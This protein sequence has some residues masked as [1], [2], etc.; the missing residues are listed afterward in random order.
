MKL[1]WQISIIAILSLS[2]PW[3]VW[4]AFKSL[5]Q[6]FQDNMLAAAGK[7]A[8]VIVNSVQQYHQDRPGDLQGFVPMALG[9]EVAIDG[10]D[11][12]WNQIP[13]Y[14]VNHQLRFKLGRHQGL[15]HLFIE[16]MD[17][18]RYTSLTLPADRLVLATGEDRGIKKHTLKRQAVGQVF[19]ALGETDFSA[20]WHEMATGYQVEIKLLNPDLKRLGLAAINHATADSFISFGHLAGDQIQLTPIFLTSDN[21]QNFLQQITPEDGQITLKDPQGRVYQQT[22]NLSS[23]PESVGWL[24]EMIYE[25]AFDQNQADGSHFFGQRVQQNFAGGQI[26]LTIRHNQAQMALIRTFIRSVMWIFAIALALLLGYFLFAIVLAWRIRRLNKNLQNVLDER[27]HIHTALPSASAKDEIGDLSRGMS[28][29]LS[30]IDEYTEYLK[31]L[32]SRLSHEMKTPI[33]IVSTSLE[34][35]QMEQ[36]NNAFVSRALSANHRLKFI[37]NQLSALSKLKQVISETDKEPFELGSF[38]EELVN[39]Y[40]LNAEHIRCVVSNSPTTIAG[41]K[42]LMA[43]MLDKLIQNALDFTTSED[44]ITVELEHSNNGQNFELKVIN[45]GSQIPVEKVHQLFD[46]LTSFRHNKNSDEPH[47]GLGLYIARLICDYHQ[48]SIS[49]HNLNEA[50]VFVITGPL[51]NR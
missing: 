9:N 20:Y 51:S 32:G 24:T 19:Q 22:S 42:E 23:E 6:T 10:I 45:T 35:L 3:V 4:Q 25:L 1:K 11:T 27:G 30:Q 34:N 5:N 48:A 18:S 7:Q 8:Q 43:Q 40:R 2:F 33:S 26:E 41:S 49:A 14:H 47:L 44:R 12:E 50:V 29:L 17:N 46:S 21:W 13:W 38:V 39:G 36:P 28:A 16:V 15:Y 31:Q 37:L